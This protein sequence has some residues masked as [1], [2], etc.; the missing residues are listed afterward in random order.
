VGAGSVE[1]ERTFWTRVSRIFLRDPGVPFF[2]SRAATERGRVDAFRFYASC[3]RRMVPMYLFNAVLVLAVAVVPR[4]GS[5]SVYLA[6]PGYPDQW[7]SVVGGRSG[8]ADP[9]CT[10]RNIAAGWVGA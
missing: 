3:L 1:G 5:R 4:S 6:F 8:G 2:W 7:L 10:V 9:R